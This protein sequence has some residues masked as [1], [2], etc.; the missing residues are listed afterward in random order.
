MAFSV[1]LK[2]LHS[3]T[4]P[5][6]AVKENVNHAWEETELGLGFL[7]FRIGNLLYLSFSFGSISRQLIDENPEGVISFLVILFFFRHQG[8][9]KGTVVLAF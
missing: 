3:F 2:V 7:G 5:F 6:L 1:S 9:N 4:S 8:L